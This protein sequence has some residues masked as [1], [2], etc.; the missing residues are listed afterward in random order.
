MPSSV[1]HLFL[2]S[3]IATAA[4][5]LLPH[6]TAL[7]SDHHGKAEQATKGAVEAVHLNQ[8]GFTPSGPKTAIVVT[9]AQSPMAFQVRS[10]KGKGLFK[11]MTTVFGVNEGSAK[12]VHQI[13]FSKLDEAGEGLFVEVGGVKSEP[14][15]IAADIY[16]T[17]KYDVLSFFY[18][19]RSGVPIEMPYAGSEE[20]TRPAGHPSDTATCFGP[21]DVNGNNW[22]G[23]TYTL[24]TTGGWYDAGDHGKYVVNSGISTWTLQNYWERIAGTPKAAAFADGAVNIPEAGNDV[25]DLLDEARYNLTFML[26]MQVPEGTS[27]NLPKGNQYGQEKT[28]D[29]TP[30]DASGM[31]HHKMHDEFWTPLPQM[32]HEDPATRY[33]TYPS[34]PAT[35]NLAGVAA[36]CGRIWRGIDDEFAA[37]CLSAAETAYAAAK[38]VPDVAGYTV[39]NGGGGGYGD[40]NFSDEFYWA[41]AELYLTTGDE[42]Y[43][44][45]MKASEH[46]LAA[47]ASMGWGSVAALG[48]LS[49]ML[50]LDA[51]SD[52]KASTLRTNVVGLADDFLEIA[53]SEGYA[54]PFDG[55]YNWGSNSGVANHGI[56]LAYAYDATGEE[57]YRDGTIDLVDYILGRNP[58]NQSYVSGYGENPMLN[59]HHRFWAKQADDRFP[60]P[61]PGALSGGSNNGNPADDVA[62]SIYDN[63]QP[64]T[65][66][67]DDIGSYSLNEV[68]INWNAPM[69]W[70]AAFADER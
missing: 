54:I 2:T 42:K 33:L 31:A 51:L 52:D 24:D 1:R 58:I 64:Q 7:A 28:L 20:F 65:C 18:H 59:P 26:A 3:A 25:P 47:P 66:Y 41:A 36:Q 50:N 22:G 69:F 70:V 32:P 15:D 23:C 40:T 57:K 49:L 34:T 21:E 19:Q 38:R 30:T 16:E 61:P 11:G 13:D 62:R 4:T 55:P 45:D 46:Y 53:D 67:K 60:G 63:C 35:L 56:V 9:D 68:A 44:A 27:M 39:T 6:A 8:V 17:L 43:H 29:L 5:T 10:A 14:F 37:K 12:A 48:N